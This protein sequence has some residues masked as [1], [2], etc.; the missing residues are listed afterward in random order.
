MAQTTS[1]EGL[2]EEGGRGP[3][4][5]PRKLRAE[6]TSDI[7]GLAD[8]SSSRHM[9]AIATAW[10]SSLAPNFPLRLGSA[11]SGVVN[12][13]FSGD[14]FKQHNSKAIN[15]CFYGELTGSLI[16]GSAIPVSFHNS[17]GHVGLVQGRSE[18]G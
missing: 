7:N 9:A 2:V 16:L 6:T 14:Q 8:A 11:S 12:D 4:S 3:L 13:S 18:L 10:F 17:G 5:V 1:S 15:I